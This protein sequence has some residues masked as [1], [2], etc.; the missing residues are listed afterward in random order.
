[1]TRQ[2]PIAQGRCAPNQPEP[3]RGRTPPVS[4]GQRAALRRPLAA[5]LAGHVILLASLLALAH[6]QPKALL[7]APLTEIS[8]VTSTAAP[9]TLPSPALVP[10]PEPAS[11]ITPAPADAIPVPPPVAASASP[12]PQAVSPAPPIE[13][14]VPLPE[15][16]RTQ[17]QALQKRPPRRPVRSRTV[18]VPVQTAPRPNLP[19]QNG[20]IAALPPSSS[21]ASPPAAAAYSSGAWQ[22]ALAAWLQAH[23][24]Y[25]EQARRDGIEGRVVVRFAVDREGTVKQV[26]LVH[27]SGS[28]ELD[29]A[30]MAMLRGSHLPP[31]PAPAPDTISITLPI[32]YSLDS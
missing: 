30:A 14:T 4:P 1:M 31:P 12:V 6:R 8:V 26:N 19:T 2:G 25:P 27:S 32:H 22:G 13:A 28:S 15:P 20:R 9:G 11:T 7:P 21:A 23:K 3:G 10:A 18:P 16:E 29:E 17:P 24:R 5:A